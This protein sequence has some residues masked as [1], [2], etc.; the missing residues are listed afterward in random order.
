MQN[1]FRLGEH[2]LQGVHMGDGVGVWYEST[3]EPR[4]L[5][6]QQCELDL[7]G[8]RDEKASRP[9]EKLYVLAKLVLQRSAENADHGPVGP[10]QGREAAE[11]GDGV[12]HGE[13]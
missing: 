1:V 12:C 4:E 9:A 5:L 7:T 3:V 10:V 6:D 13:P 8:W 2:L 11:K